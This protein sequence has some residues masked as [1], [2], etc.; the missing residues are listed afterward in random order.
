MAQLLVRNLEEDLVA[1]LKAR[2][3]ANGR[4]VEA[5][6]RQIL[7]EALAPDDAEACGFWGLAARLRAETAGTPVTPSE[8]LQREGREER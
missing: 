3:A 7:R 1:R 2:A 6:H 4:S 5:E 8:V